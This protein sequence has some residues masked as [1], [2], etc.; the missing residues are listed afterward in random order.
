MKNQKINFGNLRD[1]EKFETSK[2]SQILSTYRL[3]L[4]KN[5]PSVNFANFIEGA[6]KNNYFDSVPW[7][8]EFCKKGDLN[9]FNK[10]DEAL[11][12]L[13][14]N[15]ATKKVKDRGFN[16]GLIGDL[17]QNTLL[18]VYESVKLGKFD[19]F[20]EI[21]LIRSSVRIIANNIEDIHR[22]KDK[23]SHFVKTRLFKQTEGGNL[24]INSL[25]QYGEISKISIA[26]PQEIGNLCNS[27]SSKNEI[28]SALN[29][30]NDNY[31]EI[32]SLR[33]AENLEHSEIAKFL[34][35]SIQNSQTRLERALKSLKSKIKERV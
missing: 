5:T 28:E 32:I 8:I 15:I 33:F 19:N 35:I 17:V 22:P 21:D 24:E 30:I 16:T 9:A 34:D 6:A 13:L 3:D 20:E 1:V 12:P 31:K 23:N 26:E 10:L 29:L 14:K 18:K 4:Y 2:N 27:D 25:N 7:L 11:R